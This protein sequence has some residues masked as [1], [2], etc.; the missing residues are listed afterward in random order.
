MW[1]APVTKT[2]DG[3]LVAP[4][5]HAERTEGLMVDAASADGAVIGLLLPF[6]RNEDGNALR[7]RVG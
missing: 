6:I 1:G 7:V 4:E 5:D 2:E 3:G